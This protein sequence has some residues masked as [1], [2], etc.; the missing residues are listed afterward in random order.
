MS[1][2]LDT[3]LGEDLLIRKERFIEGNFFYSNLLACYERKIYCRLLVSWLLAFVLNALD[4]S[5]ILRYDS[6]ADTDKL[7]LLFETSVYRD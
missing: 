3:F 6:F 4:Q 1:V 2:H 7:D 5:C